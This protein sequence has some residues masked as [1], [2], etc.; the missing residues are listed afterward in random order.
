M[1]RIFDAVAAL[2]RRLGPG[3]RQVVNRLLYEAIYSVPA[4]TRLGCF[5]GGHHPPP[6][7]MLDVPALAEARLEAALYDMALRVH[8]GPLDP[9]P[10]RILDIGCGLGGGLL[11][12]AAL[13][14][15]AALTGVDQSWRAVAGA[16]RRLAAAG[17]GAAIRRAGG[18]RLSFADASFDLIAGIGSATYVGYPEFLREASRLLAPGGVLTIT[19]GTSFNRVEATRDRLA[20]LAAAS[21]LELRRFEDMTGPCFAALQLQAARNAALIARLPGVLRGYAAEWAVLPGSRRHGLY[22]SGEK[23]EFGAVFAKT[24]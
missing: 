11:Y 7:G 21:G 9:P 5:N 23:A 16:R 10:A 14:P 24:R 18:A 3:G 19:A 20:G 12:A 6:P 22:L 13:F 2:R 15:G 17:V 4:I 1:S 8:P